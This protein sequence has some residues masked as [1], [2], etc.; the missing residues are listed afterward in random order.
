MLFLGLQLRLQVSNNLSASIVL[1][2][3]LG[4]DCDQFAYFLESLLIANLG[5]VPTHGGIG[6]SFI[7]H[8]YYTKKP[9]ELPKIIA[10]SKQTGRWS[11]FALA[12]QI[13]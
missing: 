2:P 7:L 8:S 1:F 4:V 9:T 11:A 12:P 6:P 5:A 10:A 13:V 3:Q